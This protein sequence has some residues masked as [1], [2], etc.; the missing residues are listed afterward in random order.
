[1]G[2]LGNREQDQCGARAKLHRDRWHS[3]LPRIVGSRRWN[4]RTN[5]VPV[6]TVN[7][8]PTDLTSLVKPHS[9]ATTRAR[10]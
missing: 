5:P 4:A 9:D 2:F 6:H 8:E 3:L 7:G 10:S 1:M